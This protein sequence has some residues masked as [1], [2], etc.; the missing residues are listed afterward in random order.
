MM[1]PSFS[2]LSG[3]FIIETISGDLVTTAPHAPPRVKDLQNVSNRIPTG[4]DLPSK[5]P[6][7][8]QGRLIVLYFH[9]LDGALKQG[10]I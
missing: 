1:L 5:L 2:C 8:G 3:I 10:K 4:Y 7:I 6:K 9:S